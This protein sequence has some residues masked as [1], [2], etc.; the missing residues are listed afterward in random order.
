MRLIDRFAYINH[1]I[2]D[3]RA[4]RRARRPPS[5]PAR[6][7]RCSATP[8]RAD[9]HARPRPRRAFRGAGAIV[10]GER[11]GAAM[12]ELRDF[13]FE[14]V[15]LGPVARASTPRSNAS[16]RVLFDHYCAHP[17]RDPGLD[18][19]RRARARVTDYIAGMTDRYCIRR[20]RGSS[21]RV[22]RVGVRAREPLHR[23]LPRR[24]SDAV[25]MMELVRRAPSCAGPAPTATSACARFTTSAR[26]RSASGPT[27]SSTT[28]SAARRRVTRSL[29]DGDR[30]ARLRRRDRVAGRPLR[31][32]AGDRGGGPRA[33]E[34]ARGGASGCTRCWGGPRPTTRASCGRRARRAGARVPARARARGGDA[35][36][37][38]RRLRAERLGSHAARLA[39]SGFSEAELLAAGLVQRSED[40]P[41]QRLRPL[42]PADHVP[43]CATRA[44]ACSVSAP[45]RCATTS[46]PSTSTP[47]TARST[48]SARCCSGSISRA[49][50]GR[51]AG[52]MVLVEGYTDVIALHQAGLR[53]AS[54]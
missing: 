17:E 19:R 27:R 5:C 26:R 16:S 42:P 15:Y 52:R 6:R 36:R 30:G 14:R 22:R 13:M 40:R 43:G 20:V 28:A 35:A 3:A 41:G 37:V 11:G 51:R 34:R 33:A 23:R 25:D 53:N 44:A 38:S 12:S 8:A 48:T 10:Q 50:R 1:D 4:G 21:G 49:R 45:A 7:S 29:R 9:R 24:V 39:A 31:R 2:D 47:P 54:G 32:Q 46:G 18:P